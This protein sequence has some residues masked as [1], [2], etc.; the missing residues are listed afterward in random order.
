MPYAWVEPE[1]A[2]GYNGVKIYFVY[3]DD[4]FSNETRTF[5]YGYSIFSDDQGE[6]SFD[7]RD[8]AKMIGMPCSEGWDEIEAVLKAAIDKGILTQDGIQDKIEVEINGKK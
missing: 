4:K 6:D 3:R 5:W 7:V 1:I 8:L 2:L